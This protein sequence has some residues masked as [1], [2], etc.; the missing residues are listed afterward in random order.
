[1]KFYTSIDPGDNTFN[2]TLFEWDGP[3]PS[4][5]I[6][7]QEPATAVDG[8]WMEVD[9]SAE[10]VMFDGDF[11]VGFGSIN[12]TTYVG[13]DA[14]LDNGR[15]WDYD[16]GSGAWSTW[17]EAYLI[18]AIVE[19]EGGVIEELGGIS[20]SDKPVISRSFANV[21]HP[22]NVTNVEQ[23]PPMNN[24]SVDGLELEGYN[25]FRDGSKINGD[26]VETEEYM[27]MDV[28]ISTVEY[29]VTAVYT[30]GES[31]P[32]NTVEVVVTSVIDNKESLIKIYPNPA[33]NVLNI[34]AGANVQMLT[35]MNTAGQMV[36]QNSIEQGTT[37]IDINDYRSGVYILQIES[38]G[39]KITRKIVVE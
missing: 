15:S 24:R 13:Y 17:N 38:E 18:R 27:D 14:G 36:Y 11:V 25:V 26:L 23:A 3:E 8:D 37:R 32:S 35:I 19:Y 1:M 6:T 33:S 34:E 29:Y 5:T 30:G 2:A 12:G 16:N 4:S 21:S 39:Q 9:I 20:T 10:N 31:D 7:Y 28:P 22:R